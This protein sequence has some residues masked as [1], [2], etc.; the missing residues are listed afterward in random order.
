METIETE[1]FNLLD[2][3]I[4]HFPDRSARWLLQD[5]ENVRGLL[6]IVASELVERIDFS[7]LAE[8]NRSF[9][10]DTLREQESDMVFSVPFQGGSQTDELLI[11]ILIEHQSTVDA[12]MG[13]RLLFYM[14]QLWDSQRREWESENV[15]RSEW[16]LRPILPIV[17][18]TGAQHWQSPLILAALMDIPDVLS[19]FVPTFDSLFLSVKETD[20]SNLTRTGHPFG[21][22][23]TVL[24][25]EGANK[26]S[27]SDALLA[28]MSRLNALDVEQSSQKTAC[29]RVS[30]VV[31]S[32]SSSA[33]RAFGF[34]KAP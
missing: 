28:A 12:T 19:R 2:I 22:L 33:R 26:E 10:S 5:K 13:F 27:L 1:P 9:I 7:Q 30:A 18:Y 3:P 14:T 23:L 16:R 24:Q 17:F 31:G 8:V 6:E 21:W 34:G 32:A 20:E 25:K 15:P 29:D 4:R 11:Y